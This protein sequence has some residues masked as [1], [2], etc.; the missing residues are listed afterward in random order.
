MDKLRTVL[1]FLAVLLLCAVPFYLLLGVEPYLEPVQ[2]LIASNAAVLLTALGFAPVQQSYFLFLQGSGLEVAAACIGWR[3]ALAFIALVLATPFR[4]MKLRAL[5][6]LPVIHGFNLARIATSL[7]AGALL[8]DWSGL[9]HGFLW[10]YGMTFLV[11]G[12]W[13]HWASRTAPGRASH[14]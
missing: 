1:R 6:Y 2:E 12:L 9:V 14:L 8:P 4:P 13:W 10:T 5:P 3:S 7:L 11:L